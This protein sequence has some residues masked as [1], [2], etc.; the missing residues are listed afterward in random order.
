MHAPALSVAGSLQTRVGPQPV[1]LTA[2]FLLEIMQQ[3]TQILATTA[4]LILRLQPL[5]EL[6]EIQLQERV[7]AMDGRGTLD[8]EPC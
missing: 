3:N 1:D 4:Q 7:D 8:P 6:A 5:I 2:G